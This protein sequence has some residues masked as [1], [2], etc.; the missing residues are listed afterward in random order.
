MSVSSVLMSKTVPFQLIQFSISMQ[1][2]SVYP[3]DR[4]LPGAIAMK[5]CSAFSKA[6]ESL[7]PHH[8][9]VLCYIRTLVGVR[10]LLMCR[11]AVGGFYSPS[12]LGKV[13][14]GLRVLGGDFDA[15]L[16]H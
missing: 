16:L 6:P 10:V 14:N 3:I 12:Q 2:S 4:A 9:I 5:G 8:Q 11:G 13:R 7:E 15:V 1:F